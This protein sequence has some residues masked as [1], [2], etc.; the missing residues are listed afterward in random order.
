MNMENTKYYHI[1]YFLKIGTDEYVVI[2]CVFQSSLSIS[3]SN[4]V[5][6]KKKF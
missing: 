1:F 5:I 6:K 2:F 3:Y 4:W